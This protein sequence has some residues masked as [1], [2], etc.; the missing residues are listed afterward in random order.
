MYWMLVSSLDYCQLL[1]LIREPKVHSKRR[2]NKPQNLAVPDQIIR[3]VVQELHVLVI[4]LDDVEVFL[5]PLGVNGL[6]KDG[7]ATGD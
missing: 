4:Q 2:V 3:V 1:R 5:Y 7:A 6:G